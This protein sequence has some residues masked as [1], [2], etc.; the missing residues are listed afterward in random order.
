MVSLK[1]SEGYSRNKENSLAGHTQWA[2]KKEGQRSITRI[3]NKT[4][5]INEED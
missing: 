3:Y 2:R 1:F 4:V 5:K